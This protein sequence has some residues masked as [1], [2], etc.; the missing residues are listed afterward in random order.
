MTTMAKS[1]SVLETRTS[2]YQQGMANATRIAID[3]IGVAGTGVATIVKARAGTTSRQ[4]EVPRITTSAS[5]TKQ[6][7]LAIVT[8]L[9]GTQ[10]AFRAATAM[11]RPK[12]TDAME[13][14]MELSLSEVGEEER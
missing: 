9:A 5:T 2:K 13:N 8:M 10:G 6:S 1:R 14:V 4:R 7:D 11:I 12:D 3:P